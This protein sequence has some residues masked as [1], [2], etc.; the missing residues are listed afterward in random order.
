M[1]NHKK[2]II[3]KNYNTSRWTNFDLD[4]GP[5]GYGGHGGK[6]LVKLGRVCPV[7]RFCCCRFEITSGK[8]FKTFFR[9]FQLLERNLLNVKSLC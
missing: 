3:Q 8:R 7:S 2:E 5:G 6:F 4:I 1:S 9:G